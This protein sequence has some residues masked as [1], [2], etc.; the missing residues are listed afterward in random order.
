MS[1]IVH[2]RTARGA[3]RTAAAAAA[4]AF[5]LLRGPSLS[6]QG[7]C[8]GCDRMAAPAFPAT[9]VAAAAQAGAT[10]AKDAYQSWCTSQRARLATEMETIG[11]RCAKAPGTLAAAGRRALGSQ[12]DDLFVVWNQLRQACPSIGAPPAG[13]AGGASTGR[14]SSQNGAGGSSVS[15]AGLHRAAPAAQLALVRLVAALP[16]DRKGAIQSTVGLAPL[17]IADRAGQSVDSALQQIDSTT[18]AQPTGPSGTPSPS[19]P[20]QS[21]VDSSSQTAGQPAPVTPPPPLP[22]PPNATPADSAGLGYAS[23]LRSER[24]YLGGFLASYA[25]YLAARQSKNLTG[26]LS[27]AANMGV[28]IDSALTNAHTAADRRHAYLSLIARALGQADSAMHARRN[29][30]VQAVAAAAPADTTSASPGAQA[31]LAAAAVPQDDMTV[32]QQAAQAVPATQLRDSA[33]ALQQ[34]VRASDNLRMPL[35]P[36][37]SASASDSE[38]VAPHPPDLGRLLRAKGLALQS[39]QEA[40]Q[41]LGDSLVTSRPTV[42]ASGGPAGP[43]ADGSGK[44]RWWLV[45]LAL[46]LG[47]GA[48]FPAGRIV[49]RRASD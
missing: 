11:A 44:K 1:V 30:A 46:V 47:A 43:A 37:D 19:Q 34:E 23:A 14:A 20:G 35:A 39:R 7:F 18:P 22:L 49:E 31:A 15:S 17:V 4:V 42:V 45:A 38:A 6:A 33:A 41:A 8:H 27:A 26:M 16:P 28:T 48:G 3:A 32:A 9:P 13:P 10:S 5:A 29:A 2:P 24:A 40:A 25:L 12:Y 36:G 21:A